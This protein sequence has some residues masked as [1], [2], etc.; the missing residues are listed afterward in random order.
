MH[1]SAVTQSAKSADVSEKSRSSEKLHAITALSPDHA[2][3]VRKWAYDWQ[4]NTTPEG[5]KMALDDVKKPNSWAT[6]QYHATQ[7]L[8]VRDLPELQRQGIADKDGNITLYRGVNG[9]FAQELRTAASGGVG[10]ASMRVRELASWT[11]DRRTAESFAGD[12][13]VVTTAKIHHSR[14]FAAHMYETQH[15]LQ[16]WSSESE[17]AILNE[18]GSVRV[19]VED[20]FKE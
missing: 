10:E 8:I 19:K 6:A 12:Y 20:T 7:A 5:A 15:Y 17:W 4:E 3:A 16:N 2:E 14:A 1:Q 13:G 18:T 9:T 11:T